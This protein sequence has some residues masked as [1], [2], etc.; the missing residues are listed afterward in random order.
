MKKSLVIFVLLFLYVINSYAQDKTSTQTEKIRQEL[1]NWLAE[2]KGQPNSPEIEKLIEQQLKKTETGKPLG[3]EEQ[4][5][6]YTALS[7]FYQ[8]NAFW[9]ANPSYENIITKRLVTNTTALCASGGF[10]SPNFNNAFT[11]FG[12]IF[13]G[14]GSTNCTMVNNL[15]WNPTIASSPTGNVSNRMEVVSAGL[16]PTI[17][18]LTKT[19]TGNGALRINSPRN[20]AGEGCNQYR[21]G[22]EIDKAATTF[23]VDANNTSLTFWYA[24]V[25]QHPEHNDY[26]G[27]NPFFTARIRNESTGAL[28]QQICLDPSQNNLQFGDFNCN[29]NVLWKPWSCATFDLSR[30][31]GQQVTLEFIMADC[32]QGYHYGYAYIDDICISCNTPGNNGALTITAKNYCNTD[33]VSYSGTYAI[34]TTAGATLQS[35]RVQLTS[36]GALV[37]NLT[38]AFANGTFRGAI[39]SAW[40]ASGTGYDLIAIAT[41]NVPGTGTVIN[42]TEVWP[43][44]NNDLSA[45]C[46]DSTDT[47]AFTIATSCNNGTL[48]VTATSTEPTPTNH[49]WYLMQSNVAGN[50]SNAATIGQVGGT[51]TGT[52]TT[53]TITDLG[54]FYYI[55]H[56]IF[57]SA[58]YGQ[59]ELRIPIQMPQA[60]NIFN[61]EDASGTAKNTF[62]LGEDVYLDGTAS[63]GENAYF[64]DAWRRP[65][66][67]TAP[68]TWYSGL[69]WFQGQAGIVNLSQAFRT[70]GNPIVNFEQGYEYSI[71]LALQNLPNCIGWTPRELTFKVICC[72]DNINPNYLLSVTPATTSYTL[73]A[74]NFN[75]HATVNAVH[76]WYVLSSPNATS[77]PYSP[78]ASRQSTTQT[79]VALLTNAQ[80]GLYYTVI[81]KVRTLCGEVCIKRVQYQSGLSKSAAPVDTAASRVDCCLAFQYWPNGPGLPLIYT[82]NFN[83]T[84]AATTPP[85]AG[86]YTIRASNALSYSNNPSVTHEWYVLS[87][88]N[89]NNGPYMAVTQSTGYNFSFS[90]AVDG[91]YYFVIH[92]VKSPCS[93]VCYGQRICRSCIPLRNVNCT[94]CGPLD[95]SILDTVWKPCNTPVNLVSN[96]RTN[97]L[98]WGAVP[99]L[100]GYTVEISF[101]DRACC[102]ST[103]L[104]TANMYNT[105]TNSLALSSIRTPAYDCFRWRVTTKCDNGKMAWSDWTCFSCTALTPVPGP[106]EIKIQ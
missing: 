27:E 80:Y 74:Q 83:I 55:K 86:Q 50:T 59:R 45:F 84:T 21:Y 67:S 28:I 13:N 43:G 77:G 98:T 35:L 2:R 32:G 64:I 51:Q 29:T 49:Q 78:V 41:F 58:C 79:T 99:G 106:K 94:L 3:I 7:A 44:I 63:S 81:H 57:N 42:A 9:K 65:I 31:I 88:P 100:Q 101:N 10:E 12:S 72:T 103:K 47:P 85:V 96:C 8:E 4:K 61:F 70:T 6:Q 105:T 24:L 14:G 91:L 62:C 76:E 46:C 39:P 90:P 18:G 52:A 16:D 95:C 82:A 15:A 102:N 92:K 75:I 5:Q 33:S 48:T 37:A 71:K 22:K 60:N 56:I 30:A 69:G 68:F 19:R 66:G 23:T 87:S 38:P 34:P 97:T 40:L 11:H 25:M 93:I 73:T 26:N 54:K 104:P 53:F 89:A 36:G 1:T 20:A 17:P